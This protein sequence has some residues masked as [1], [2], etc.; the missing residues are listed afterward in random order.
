MSHHIP[1]PIFG[2]FQLQSSYLAQQKVCTCMY[3]CMYVCM[4]VFIDM[5]SQELI[6]QKRINFP[7]FRNTEEMNNMD[8]KS[9]GT[10]ISTTEIE[11]QNSITFPLNYL[12]D[13]VA[14][15]SCRMTTRLSASTM[16][17]RVTLCS[18]TI[19]S[20]SSLCHLIGRF[21]VP[22]DWSVRYAV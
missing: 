17:L 4:H 18:G 19:R 11:F 10:E 7:K 9:F 8:T 6:H 1:T 15:S 14:V 5:C 3:V 13:S 21:V 22:S 16:L 20:T 2:V 12:A